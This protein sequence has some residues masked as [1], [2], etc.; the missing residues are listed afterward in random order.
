MACNIAITEVLGVILTP[1]DTTTTAVRVSGTLSGDC[2][3]VVTGNMSI[4]VVITID[5]GNGP[6]NATAQNIGGNWTAEAPMTC[7]CGNP[8]VVTATC[9]SDPTCTDTFDGVLDCP[10][11]PD[12]PNVLVDFTAGICDDGKRNITLVAF[13]SDPLTP[14]AHW[15]YGDLTP[16]QPSFQ[17]TSG[18][19]HFASHP[20]IPGN[21]T[22]TLHIDGCPPENLVIDVE[23]CPPVQMCPSTSIIETRGNCKNDGTQP[24]T[25]TATLT[26]T[27]G[28]TI[29][30][31]LKEGN[32][33]LTSGTS[34]TGTLSLTGPTIDYASGTHTVTV[35]V[36]EPAENC[37]DSSLTFDVECGITG[38][39]C[40]PDDSCEEIT[41][42][43]CRARDGDYKG[44]GTSCADVDC[45]GTSFCGSLL[46]IVAALLAIATVATIIA[47]ALQICPAFISVPVP[48]W[49][50]GI[51]AGIWIAAAA[52]IILWYVLCAF[53]ICDCPT[54]CDWAAIAWVVALAA[55]IVSLY[56]V[57]CCGPLWWWLVAGFGATF[58]ATFAFWLLECN[59]ST[60]TVLDLLLVAFAT[61]ASTALVYIVL[62]PQIMACGQTWVEVA[63]ASIVAVL[64]V[65][66][67]ACHAAE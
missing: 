46:F 59:P 36:T 50:W 67:P 11:P 25:I 65:A 27:P 42:D 24:V 38:A 8:I 12:C 33:V 5:C 52:A 56:L 31:E 19:F 49:L 41:E 18:N 3:P 14:M 57:T 7:E 37:P 39:C 62:I 16:D 6:V 48:A 23:E 35:N 9:V 34:S 17:L 47:L 28:V 64:A 15:E 22:A 30:A 1:Q 29:T 61:I 20:Y 45:G 63:V 21:Y 51:I 10:P 4:H 54:R 55:A 58:T 43:E 44:D 60:C 32:N 2:T 66:V 13:H 26:G 53:G 40:L